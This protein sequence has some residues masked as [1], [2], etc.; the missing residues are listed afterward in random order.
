MNSIS[1]KV[2]YLSGLLDGLDIDKGTKEGK[3]LVEV[4]N[5]LKDMAEEILQVSECQKDMQNYIDAIDE[6]LSDLQENFYDDDYELCQDEGNNFI[7][8]NCPNCT[9]VVYVDKDIIEHEKEI[10]C[11]NCHSKISLQQHD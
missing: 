2:S 4:I 5:I 1:S 11:P 3:I 9:D 8:I 7:Q 6:D 10:A